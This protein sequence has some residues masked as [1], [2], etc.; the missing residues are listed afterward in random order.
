MFP[1]IS[2]KECTNNNQFVFNQINSAVPII[3]PMI[4]PICVMYSHSTERQ[5]LL[6]PAP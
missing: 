2:F 4:V 1:L 5:S 3:V 6:P